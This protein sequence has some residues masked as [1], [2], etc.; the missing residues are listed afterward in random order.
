MPVFSGF[1]G[2]A[3]R[4]NQ[5]RSNQYSDRRALNSIR[6]KTV[7]YY[8]AADMARCERNEEILRIKLTARAEAAASV[9]FDHLD[10]VDGDIYLLQPQTVS[11]PCT[12]FHSA[13]TPRGSKGSAVW[14]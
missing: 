7:N 12:A 8:R 11:R 2:S 6:E 5:Q 1:A 9:A 13:S 10:R 3:Q 14:R 4:S